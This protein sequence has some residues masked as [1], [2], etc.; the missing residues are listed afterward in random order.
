MNC[1]MRDC[2][3]FDCNLGLGGACSIL[4][5]SCVYP[6]HV[7]TVYNFEFR[8][9]KTHLPLSLDGQ[10][11]FLGDLENGKVAL[12]HIPSKIEFRLPKSYILAIS[13]INSQ[14]FD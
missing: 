5:G 14:D 12:K 8:N 10:Y 4:S 9:K 2:D 3:C 11:K 13:N 7:G 6:F 1:K